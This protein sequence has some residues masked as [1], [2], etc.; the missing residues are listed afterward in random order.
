[1]VKNIPVIFAM[2]MKKTYT[3]KPKENSVTIDDLTD[4]E[5]FVKANS[6]AYKNEQLKDG[7]YLNHTSFM[8]QIP[9]PGNY[10][11]EKNEKGAVLR[12]IKEENGKK[13]KISANEMFIYVQNGKAYKKTYSGF[14]ELNKNDRGF[15]LVSNRSYILS[16]QNSAVFLALVQDKEGCM[17]VLLLV[18]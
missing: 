15:Y 14:L 8:N 10:V 18:L 9:E 13:D 12:A 4:Y 16:V 3:L 6:E 11:F 17:E 2:F 7:I 5:S 1:M